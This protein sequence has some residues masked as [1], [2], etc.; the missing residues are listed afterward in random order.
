MKRLNWVVCFTLLVLAGC[1][2]NQ[3]EIIKYRELVQ[4]KDYKSALSIMK[5]DS[6]YQDE[7]SR[8]LKYLELGTLHLYSGEFYQALQHFDLARELSD[9]LFTVSI[10]KKI[11]GIAVNQSADNYY[12]ERYERSL[13]RYYTILC[14]YNLYEKGEYE[15][16]KEEKR[17]DKGKVAST[18]DVVLVTLDESKKRFH[19]QSRESYFA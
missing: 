2:G 10:S 19:L 14:H 18:T 9:K 11:A 17:D 1:A 12:G 15:A 16:Y 4:K 7:E 3:K 8:L 5:G 6:I 13:I